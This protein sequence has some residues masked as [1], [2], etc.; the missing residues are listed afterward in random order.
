[1]PFM[2][3]LKRMTVCISLPRRASWLLKAELILECLMKHGVAHF[4]GY[5]EAMEEFNNIWK[6]M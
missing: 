1:M 2:G 3:V 5:D 6:G 4:E